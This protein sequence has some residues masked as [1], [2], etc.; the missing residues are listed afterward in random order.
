[1]RSVDTN[2]VG[3]IGQDEATGMI[4][5]QMGTCSQCD[6][7]VFWAR[8]VKRDNS[9]GKPAPFDIEPSTQGEFMITAREVGKEGEHLAA[10]RWGKS[11][12][13]DRY[14]IHF[15]TCANATQ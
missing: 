1:M 15:N 8:V 9:S 5:D 6:Q 14:E 13:E 7:P 11:R 2:S 3:D 4:T 12:D 10:H